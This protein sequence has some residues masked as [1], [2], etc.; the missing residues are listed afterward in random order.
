MKLRKL[1]FT[2]NVVWLITLSIFLS[3]KLDGIDRWK[4]EQWV[5]A[6]IGMITPLLT[7]YYFMNIDSEA[8]EDSLVGLW[9][10]VKKKKLNDQ[11]K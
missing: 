4:W 8:K 6:V 1:C 10:K 3:A 11:L 9:I 2:L 5:I 7:C